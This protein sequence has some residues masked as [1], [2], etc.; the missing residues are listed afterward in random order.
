[1]PGM[2]HRGLTGPEVRASPPRAA[3]TEPQA[4][5]HRATRCG[6]STALAAGCH[7]RPWLRQRHRR[8]RIPQREPT[9]LTGLAPPWA[10][11]AGPGHTCAW[12]APCTEWH[13]LGPGASC[14]G[15]LVPACTAPSPGPLLQPAGSHTQECSAVLV[16]EHPLQ[17]RR[18]KR[19]PAPR[20][21]PVCLPGDS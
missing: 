6:A 11:P 10:P 1:M 16:P 13:L 18:P 15:L 12:S 14:S 21:G 5:G 7:H 4:L 19:V 3:G 17:C 20:Q 2:R 8:V 9:G